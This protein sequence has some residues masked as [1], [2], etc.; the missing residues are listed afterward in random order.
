ME[1]FIETQNHL[2][3][4]IEEEYGI[5]FRLADGSFRPVNEWLDDIYDGRYIYLW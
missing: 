3:K 2:W 4:Q 1:D 5:K